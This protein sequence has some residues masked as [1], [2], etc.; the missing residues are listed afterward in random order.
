M[1][2][3]SR[4]SHWM[5][6]GAIG[7]LSVTVGGV[8]IATAAN[9]GSLR[10]GH[11]NHAK[12]TTTL[13]NSKGTALSLVAGKG[14]PPLKVNSKALVKNLNAERLDGLSAS[15]LGVTASVGE[16]NGTIAEG[17]PST[18]TDLPAPTSSGATLTYRPVLL[19]ATATLATGV[20]VANATALGDGSLCWI[21]TTARFGHE[22]FGDSSSSSFTTVS[23][24]G[25]FRLK[26]PGRLRLYCA[27]TNSTTGGK[28]VDQTLIAIKVAHYV[29]GFSTAPTAPFAP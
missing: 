11:S 16:S 4:I 15:S 29:P 18:V 23:A 3:R 21:N 22:D 13:T 25:A 10:L 24:S 7:V 14:K 28:V 20:Y 6:A 9:G 5:T 17:V 8:G 27:G 1:S 2:A 26:T 19:A 12:S